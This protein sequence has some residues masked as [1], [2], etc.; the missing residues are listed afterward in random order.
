MDLEPTKVSSTPYPTVRERLVSKRKFWPPIRG[1]LILRGD[2][3][4]G[5]SISPFTIHPCHSP[6]HLLKSSDGVSDKASKL[7]P[8]LP[9]FFSAKNGSAQ[10]YLTLSFCGSIGGVNKTARR[11]PV[12]MGESNETPIKYCAEESILCTP[13]HLGF[14]SVSFILLRFLGLDW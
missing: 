14:N 3:T 1:R 10:P 9:H 5:H 4:G 11:R 13:T 12:P 7:S 6:S 8:S 2:G